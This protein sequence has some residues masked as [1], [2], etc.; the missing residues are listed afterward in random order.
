MMEG[1]IEEGMMENDINEMV[2]SGGGG[3]RR[4]RQ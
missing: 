2:R 4:R 3:R 1:S